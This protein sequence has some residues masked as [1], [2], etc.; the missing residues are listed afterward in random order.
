MLG[1]VCCGSIGESAGGESL[2]VLEISDHPGIEEPKPNFKYVANM[3]G[4]EPAGRQLLVKLADWLCSNYPEHPW[5]R[6]TVGRMHLFLMP[7]MNPDGFAAHQRENGNQRDLNRDFP[8]RIE[9]HGNLDATGKEQPETLAVMNWIQHGSFV[10][11]A[12]LHEGA[13]VAN[14][15]WDADENGQRG[16]SAAPD[17]MVFVFLAKLYAQKHRLMHDSK[18]F[19]DGI[20]NGNAWYPVYG[21]MQDWNYLMGDCFEITLEISPN[22]WPPGETLGQL[23]ID[24]M[25]AFLT[26]PLVASLGGISGR[27]SQSQSSRWKSQDQP[28]A[29]RIHVD[30]IDRDLFSKPRFGDFYRPLPPGTYNITASL[31]G[32]EPSTATIT[33][34]ASMD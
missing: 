27:V 11:S 1:T 7:T 9:Q 5:A 4:N 23:W 13:L 33:V 2:W 30:G 15:P 14:Y 17:D 22:K 25:D 21:G 8:D 16:A 29:A 34:P 26:Y 3:H 12:D 20:T 6:A 28:L 32:Y 24:N 19:K 31:E 18:K 10:G